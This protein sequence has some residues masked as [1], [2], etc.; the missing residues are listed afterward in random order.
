MITK[1]HDFIIQR[2]WSV[3]GVG[4]YSDRKYRVRVFHK[5]INSL[6]GIY[7]GAFLHTKLVYKDAPTIYM[8]EGFHEQYYGEDLSADEPPF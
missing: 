7:Y 5:L 1:F 4:R 3:D 6:C 8:P 2:V